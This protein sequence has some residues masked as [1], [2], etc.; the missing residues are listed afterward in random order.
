MSTTSDVAVLASAAVLAVVVAGCAT[1]E[2]GIATA[3]QVGLTAASREAAVGSLPPRT[4]QV[5]IDGVDP[6][7]LLTESELDELRVN[8]KPRLDSEPR[9]GATCAFDVDLTEPYYSYAVELITTADVEAWVSGDRTKSSMTREPGN[10]DGFPAV[11]HYRAAEHPS[12]CETL[13]G[14][15]KGQTV[16]VQMYPLTQNV[17]DQQQL[18]D[19]SEQ[20]ATRVVR[21]LQEK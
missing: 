15:A 21:N 5:P 4:K 14:V 11:R 6:C 16:R 19:M 12:D 1:S 9:D 20:V 10:V 8:S 13:V 17:F 2:P 7:T 18:C 3:N